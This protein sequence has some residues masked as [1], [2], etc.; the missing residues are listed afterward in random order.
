MEFEQRLYKWHVKWTNYLNERSQSAIK[1]KSYYTHIKLRSA[2]LNSN[3]NIPYLFVFEEY[4]ELNMPNTTNA[5]DGSFSDSGTKSLNIEIQM[6]IMQ[7][8]SFS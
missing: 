5:L 8:Y 7:P 4:S 1:G 6:E 3:I 2:Y